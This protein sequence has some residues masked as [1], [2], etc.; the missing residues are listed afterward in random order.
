MT[1]N[2][3]KYIIS[4]LAVAFWGLVGTGQTIAQNNTYTSVLSE[5]TWYRLAVT[6]EGAHQLDY[7][8][9]QSMGIDMNGLN[10]NRRHALTT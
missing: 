8:T 1:I 9:L 3:K 5:H 4:V 6:Q 7:A 2:M 10:P